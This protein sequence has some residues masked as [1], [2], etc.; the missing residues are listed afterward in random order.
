MTKLPKNADGEE[1][2][3]TTRRALARVLG[4]N[5][6]TIRTHQAKGATPEL[7]DVE[8]WRSLLSNTKASSDPTYH[9]LRNEKL[10][11]EIRLLKVKEQ[12]AHG[13]LA[14]VETV[15]AYL[16][17]LGAKFDQLLTQ[18]IDTEIPARLNGKDIVAARAEAR[19]VHDEIRQA[20]NA[21]ISAWQPDDTD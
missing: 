8:G 7:G 5:E 2:T 17:K 16:A 15:R 1:A 3:P 19:A 9:E 10:A 20:V 21:G 18:K 6:A 4:C 13:K 11:T 14:A 12:Q